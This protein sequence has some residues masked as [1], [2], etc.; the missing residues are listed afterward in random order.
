MTGVDGSLRDE[1]AARTRD[2]IMRALAELL[3][4]QGPQSLSLH[5]VAERARVGER[6]LYRH[7]PNKGALYV[8]LQS[9]I[10]DAIDRAAPPASLASPS[11]L[12]ASLSAAF[13]E[14][15]RLRDAYLVVQGLPEVR[16]AM[17]IGHRERRRSITTAM[18]PATVGL[19]KAEA[20]RTAAIAHLLGSS[21]AL[22]FLQEVWEFTPEEAAAASGWAIGV[23]ADAVE[24]K[25]RGR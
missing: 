6:T 8:A 9:W 13:P 7:F 3:V 11:E 22:Y 17:A 1:Q 18:K 24:T 14:L 15:A 2:R 12:A 25:G 19:S 4:E 20:T 5:A 16:E 23:I 21:R 10:S